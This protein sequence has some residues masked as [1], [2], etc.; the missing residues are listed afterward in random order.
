MNRPVVLLTG[1][2]GYIGSHVA[3]LLVE[4]GFETVIFDNLT[5]SCVSVLE[6]LEK[7]TGKKLSFVEGDVRDFALLSQ[8]LLQYRIEA[9]IHLAGLKSVEESVNF[10]TEYYDVNL[11]GAVN[12]VR[13][14]ENA[15]IKT[16]VFSSSATVYGIPKYL[17]LDEAHPVNP[18]NPYG[19]TKQFIEVMLRD[20]VLSRSDVSV[21]CLRYF[22]PAGAH[23]SG[24]IGERPAGKPNNLMPYIARVASGE[25]DEVNVF[26]NDYSTADGSGVRDY[27]HVMD[28]AQ[29]HVASLE[30]QAS[31]NGF[32]VFNLGTGFGSSVFEVV[33]AFSS[34][35]GVNIPVRVQARRAG[36]VA[37][38][39]AKV[40]L[41]ERMLG[42]KAIRDL[43][44][45]CNSAWK[46]Q[47]L[48]AANPDFNAKK[49]GKGDAR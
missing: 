40:D 45:A 24:L 4:A 33:K 8:T 25:F 30:F 34:A 19:R 23:Q 9:V 32:Y 41:A 46:F 44:D 42:W 28:L 10:P 35:A 20:W 7:I 5:N 2:L 39:Y 6:R 1:G 47:V 31:N 48:D 43:N 27:I 21:S 26:G 29:G 16:L 14:M 3:V 15:A 22:N 49:A 36:D 13:A 11:V 12:L 38:C 17:P 18:I 37:E